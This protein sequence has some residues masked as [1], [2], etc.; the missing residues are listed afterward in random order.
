LELQVEIAIA[1]CKSEFEKEEADA[2]A[3]HLREVV[4]ESSP[5]ELFR[6]MELTVHLAELKSPY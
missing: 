4:H 6:L 1:Y 5:V 2:M 3:Q